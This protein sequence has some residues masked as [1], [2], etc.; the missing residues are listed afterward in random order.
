MDAQ[1]TCLV[2]SHLVGQVLIGF[3]N[4]QRSKTSRHEVDCHGRAVLEA[5]YFDTDRKQD[6]AVLAVLS[7][8]DPD[9]G[10]LYVEV[11]SDFRRTFPCTRMGRTN[12]QGWIVVT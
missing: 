7:V 8:T 9:T 6:V 1:D 10:Q 2:L 3:G 11:G 5:I 4:F 12:S